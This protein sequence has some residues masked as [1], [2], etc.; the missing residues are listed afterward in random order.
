[1]RGTLNQPPSGLD[2]LVINHNVAG[3][4]I[5]LEPVQKLHWRVAPPE[6]VNNPRREEVVKGALNVQENPDGNP[7]TEDGT[8]KVVHSITEG[9]VGRPDFAE[10]ML[11]AVKGGGLKNRLLQVPKDETLKRLKDKGH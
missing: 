6:A 9:G 11:V 2:A 7:L 1:M 10:G 5:V 4:K 3:D 8:L